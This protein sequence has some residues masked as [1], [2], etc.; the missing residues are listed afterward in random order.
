M[1]R[2]DTAALAARSWP[3]DNYAFRRG[4]RWL[5]EPP[6][7]RTRGPGRG[8]NASD[9]KLEEVANSTA[10]RRAPQWRDAEALFS[11]AGAA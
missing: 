9:A 10:A 3:D 2:R 8:R 5:D 1:A 11:R 4:R 7:R 6:E